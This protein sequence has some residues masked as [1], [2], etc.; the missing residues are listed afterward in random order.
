MLQLTETGTCGN[1][2]GGGRWEGQQ[3]VREGEETKKWFVWAKIDSGRIN[4]IWE[5]RGGH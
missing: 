4:I 5:A 3:R 2:R 1:E